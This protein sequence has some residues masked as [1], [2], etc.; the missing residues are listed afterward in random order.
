MTMSK[1]RA[2]AI[3][4]KV[5]FLYCTVASACFWFSTHHRHSDKLFEHSRPRLLA[6]SH[7]RLSFP[8][9]SRKG[10]CRDR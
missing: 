8:H 6:S 3:A 4:A 2:A 5:R 9:A 1:S 10:K 7:P